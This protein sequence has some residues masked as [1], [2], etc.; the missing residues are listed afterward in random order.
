MEHSDNGTIIIEGFIHFVSS[1]IFKVLNA[2]LSGYTLLKEPQ[3]TGYAFTSP[4]LRAANI[5]I[6]ER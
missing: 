4:G 2:K 3:P 6:C 5:K 1:R